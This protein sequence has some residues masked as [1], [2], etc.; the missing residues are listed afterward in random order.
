MMG[1]FSGLVKVGIDV[2]NLPIEVAKD[3]VT[4]GGVFAGRRKSYTKE[5]L[6]EM[7]EKS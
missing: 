3:V 6:E 1:F 7:K 2:V 5:A 4:F